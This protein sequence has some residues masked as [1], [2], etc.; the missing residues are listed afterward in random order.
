MTLPIITGFYAGLLAILFTVLFTRVSI[1]R[2]KSDISVY[3]GED[4]ALGLAI[5]QHGNLAESAALALVLI[6]LL[7]MAGVATWAV[8]ALGA[9]LVVARIIHPFGLKWDRINVPGRAIG[10]A[11]T[12]GVILV[13][14]VWLVYRFAVA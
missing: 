3:Y 9:V 13:S 10:V 2:G 14:G 12:L 7:E 8:H 11:G 1:L 6:A 4:Q 5:R